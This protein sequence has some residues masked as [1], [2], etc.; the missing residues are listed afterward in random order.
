MSSYKDCS[1][2]ATSGLGY[3]VSFGAA[4]ISEVWNVDVKDCNTEHGLTASKAGCS[5][6][7]LCSNG[8]VRKD[9]GLCSLLQEHNGKFV[10]SPVRTGR[11]RNCCNEK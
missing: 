5:A 7:S 9:C 3:K 10:E 2:S 4:L 1:S 6:A 11:H 8:E